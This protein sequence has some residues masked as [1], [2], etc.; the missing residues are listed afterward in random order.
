MV[1]K[2]NNAIKANYANK[3]IQMF[4]TEFEQLAEASHDAIR[5]INKDFTIRYIN[6]AFAEMTG[7]NQDNVVGKKCGEVFPGCLCHTVECRLQRILNGEQNIQVEIERK[8]KDGSTI[9]CVVTASP[10]INKTGATTGILEQFHDIT[11][12]RRMEEQIKETEE[13][14]RSLI[15]LGAEAG[16]A[17]VMLQDIDSQEGVQVFVN[18]QWL[19]ITGYTREELLGTSFFNLLSPRNREA[20]V[21]RHRL[22]ISGVSVPGLYGMDIIRRDGTTVPVELTGGYS[23]YQGKRTNIIY[24]RDISERKRTEETLQKER[25]RLSKLLEYAPVGIL[26]LDFSAGMSFIH[27]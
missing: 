22:K 10:L 27:N 25:D 2:T 15:E 13:R 20:S 11:E 5:V 4:R 19:R 23:N 9:P 3:K 16:E 26:E 1:S 8:K 17:I 21:K 6:H 18:D 7:V 14:Y 24:L 12:H